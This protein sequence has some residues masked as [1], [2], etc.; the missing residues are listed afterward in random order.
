MFICSIFQAIGVARYKN[1]SR[2]I[3]NVVPNGS[4]LC[5]KNFDS[6]Y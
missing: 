5:W 6:N 1:Q 2:E 4:G 3:V